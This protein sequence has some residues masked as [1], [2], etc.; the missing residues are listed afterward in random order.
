MTRT[1]LLLAALAAALPAAA[2]PVDGEWPEVAYAENGQCAISVT[3][4]GQVYRIAVSGLEPG[5][6]GHYVLSNGD[7]TPIDWSIRANASGEFSRYYMPFRWHREGGTVSV[8]V[9]SESCAL[10]ASFPWQR[11][12]IK[13]S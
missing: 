13:V 10:S 2:Q 1:A 7:M 9:S 12:G 5:E 8:S 6:A 11:A 3:G 4:N